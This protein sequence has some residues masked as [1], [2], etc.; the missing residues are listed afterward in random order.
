[1]PVARF[2]EAHRKLDLSVSDADAPAQL[3]IGCHDVA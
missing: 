3:R 1:M 2:M